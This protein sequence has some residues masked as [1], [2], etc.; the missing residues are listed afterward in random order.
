M[1]LTSSLH[2]VTFVIFV[3]LSLKIIPKTQKLQI[4]Q[5][6]KFS[7]LLTF[8]SEYQHFTNA[9]FCKKRPF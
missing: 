3:K 2:E 8:C 7:I 4:K 5:D 1:N 9:Q 6:I